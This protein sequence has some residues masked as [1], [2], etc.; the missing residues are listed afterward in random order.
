MT[1]KQYRPPMPQPCPF[2]G[3]ATGL[4]VHYGQPNQE[5]VELAKEGKILLGGCPIGP[6]S[7]KWQCTACGNTW[8]KWEAKK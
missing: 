6:Q 4:E 8:G 2:C 3:K 7:P 1:S 5:G